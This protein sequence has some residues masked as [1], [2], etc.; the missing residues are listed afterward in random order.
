MAKKDDEQ[1]DVPSE[2]ERQQQQID[3]QQAA[4]TP[5]EATAE[6]Q[7]ADE[8]DQ[9]QAKPQ[10][11]IRSHGPVPEGQEDQYDVVG[12]EKPAAEQVEGGDKQSTQQG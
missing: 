1:Q 10:W 9:E 8:Q 7:S 2:A 4:A 3:A 11:D 6:Q 12:D 5:P